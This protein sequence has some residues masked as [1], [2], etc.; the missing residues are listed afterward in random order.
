VPGRHYSGSRWAAFE[1]LVLAPEGK[2][3]GTGSSG[4]A[5]LGEQGKML[6][7][8]ESLETGFTYIVI[9]DNVVLT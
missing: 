9:V 3:G 4:A 7:V 1:S 2:R 6:H 5:V 8:Q